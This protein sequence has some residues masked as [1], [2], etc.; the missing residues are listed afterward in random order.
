MTL[1]TTGP[2]NG[3]FDRRSETPAEGFAIDEPVQ[4]STVLASGF[5]VLKVVGH[6]GE[7]LICLDARR[8][9]G[10]DYANSD[11]P[12]SKYLSCLEVRTPEEATTGRKQRK[13]P[14]NVLYLRRNTV[15]WHKMIGL[16]VGD[17]VFG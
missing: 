1:V 12:T 9:S 5:I 7:H 10:V 2:Y 14:K 11:T 6:H 17:A 8:R 13:T 3:M 16:F 15:G 4:L